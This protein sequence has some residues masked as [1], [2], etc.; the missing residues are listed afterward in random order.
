MLAVVGSLW[1]VGV[2]LL[3]GAVIGQ[4]VNLGG[5]ELPALTSPK[6]RWTVAA[7]GA[8]ALVLGTLLYV[9]NLS[10]TG[11]TGGGRAAGPSP[12]PSAA[13]A[14]PTDDPSPPSPAPDTS[15][16]AP[17]PSRT[18]SP[19]VPPPDTS[20]APTP[21]PG[22][23]KPAV[24]VRWQGSLLLYSNGAPT[25]WWLDGVPPGQAV[26]GDLGLECDCHSGEVVANAIARWDGSRPPDHQQCADL[27][28]Q[29]ARRALAVHEG[30]VA[31]L[32]TQE[33]RLGYVTVTS[34]RGPSEFTVEATVWDD[35]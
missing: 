11:G 4:A 32:R 34:V 5:A 18:P 22:P 23:S 30:T 12:S 19:S 26:I 16:P 13:P 31:C 24:R 1:V 3:A 10:S 2:I 6:V 7:I 20:P 9:Q 17:T 15:T 8:L 25:G 29:L 21:R 28:G 14:T 35:W 33:G 27:S